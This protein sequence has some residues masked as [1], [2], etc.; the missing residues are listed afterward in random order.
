MM[1]GAMKVRL[2][3]RRWRTRPNEAL[4]EYWRSFW[5]TPKAAVRILSAI[6][7]RSKR[8]EVRG[9]YG[10]QVLALVSVKSSDTIR[11][12]ASR[13]IDGFADSMSLTCKRYRKI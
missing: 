9:S 2:R 10:A 6:T 5:K 12:V 13:R 11:L 4:C 8:V 1:D 7:C 3:A